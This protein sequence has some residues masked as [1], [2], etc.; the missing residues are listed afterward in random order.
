MR[1]D[2]CMLLEMTL[3]CYPHK[4]LWIRR[5]HLFVYLNGSTFYVIINQFVIYFAAFQQSLWRYS[6][7]YLAEITPVL[8]RDYSSTWARLLQ[9]LGEITAVLAPS[10]ETEV[11]YS[12][13]NLLLK[14]FT[15]RE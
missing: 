3:T 4:M 7:Q 12:L 10:T 2:V 14:S 5:M 13:F 6:S 15:M 1:H 9:Y 8:G 11:L